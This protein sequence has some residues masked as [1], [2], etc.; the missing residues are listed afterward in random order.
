MATVRLSNEKRNAISYKFRKTL[1]PAFEAQI[2]ALQASVDHDRFTDLLIE[3]WVQQEGCFSVLDTMPRKWLE[4]VS[5][6][7]IASVNGVSSPHFNSL[8]PSQPRTVPFFMCRKSARYETVRVTIEANPVVDEIGLKMM[9]FN[10]LMDTQRERRGLTEREITKLLYKCSTLKQL[11]ELWSEAERYVDDED[12]EEH[13]R[14]VERTAKGKLTVSEDTLATLNSA[15]VM[16]VLST[17][18]R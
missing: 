2:K 17:A 1:E 6:F 4:E 11:L 7:Q 12:M 13:R 18:R 3:A 16:G 5:E 14:V 15:A 10:E 8:K 9:E